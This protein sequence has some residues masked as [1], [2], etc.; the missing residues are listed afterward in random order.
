M[1]LE[2]EMSQTYILGQHTPVYF[3]DSDVIHYCWSRNVFD[4]VSI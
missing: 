1:L 2:N 4:I 3:Y